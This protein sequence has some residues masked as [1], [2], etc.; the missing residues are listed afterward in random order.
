MKLPLIMC[1]HR[2]RR[3]VGVYSGIY[4][5]GGRYSVKSEK[6]KKRKHTYIEVQ[7]RDLTVECMNTMKFKTMAKT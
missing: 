2:S 5:A 6:R 3:T 7:Y 4:Q 1:V